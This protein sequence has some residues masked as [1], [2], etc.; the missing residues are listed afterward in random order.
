MSRVT[1]LEIV[2][3]MKKMSRVTFSEIVTGLK[4]CHG[5]LFRKLS[6]V[7]QIMSRV[8]FYEIFQPRIAVT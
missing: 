1:F 6:R 2:T 7:G 4:K 5:L 3:G 8:T